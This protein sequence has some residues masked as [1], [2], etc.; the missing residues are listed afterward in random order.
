MHQTFSF[1]FP[2]TGVCKPDSFE[3]NPLLEVDS[4]NLCVIPLQLAYLDHIY[5]EPDDNFHCGN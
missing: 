3:Q 5:G 1:F 4:S 2:G